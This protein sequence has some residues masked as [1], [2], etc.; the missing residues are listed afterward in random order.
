[1]KT[2]ALIQQLMPNITSLCIN[3][4]NEDHVDFILKTMLQLET[5]NNLDVDREDLDS[6]EQVL[7][8]NE[9]A[10]EEEEEQNNNYQY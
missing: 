8:T 2:V 6:E 7:E 10:V 4:Y 3:L 9:N 1:M 5:L